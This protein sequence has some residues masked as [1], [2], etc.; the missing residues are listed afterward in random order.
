MP[1]DEIPPRNPGMMHRCSFCGKTAEQVRR[2]VAGPNVFICNE[3]ILLCQEIM[4][5]DMPFMGGA[6]DPQEL[7]TPV[8]L[9]YDL[10]F[11]LFFT[12]IPHLL[13]D[14]LYSLPDTLWQLLSD[15]SELLPFGTPRFLLIPFVLLCFLGLALCAYAVVAVFALAIRELTGNLAYSL[16]P[17]IAVAFLILPILEKAMAGTSD[18]WQTVVIVLLTLVMTVGLNYWRSES[19]EDPADDYPDYRP[20]AAKIAHKLSE[21]RREKKE[22]SA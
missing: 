21:R 3:C 14:G 22:Q 20:L 13:P 4:A 2:L 17:F 9:L 1:N 8:E 10:V 12:A 16:M 18:G 19:E 5:E 7:P 6:D 11:L 15:P